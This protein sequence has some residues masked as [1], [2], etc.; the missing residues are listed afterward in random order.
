MKETD[1]QKMR[2]EFGKIEVSILRSIQIAADYFDCEH[3][4]ST[5]ITIKTMHAQT[6]NMVVA[7]IDNNSEVFNQI[8]DCLQ[9]NTATF[10]KAHTKILEER[11]KEK[12]KTMQ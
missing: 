2:D 1:L 5:M 11:L 6:L 7:T 8:K 12:S 4:L 9:K 10:I 3:F